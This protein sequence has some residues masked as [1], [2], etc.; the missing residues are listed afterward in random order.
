MRVLH[1]TTEFP[2]VVYG[3]LGT[4]LGGLVLASAASGIEAGVLLIEDHPARTYGTLA[5]DY[6]NSGPPLAD[7]TNLQVPIFRISWGEALMFGLRAVQWWQPDVLHLHVFWLWAV[8]KFLQEHTGIPLVYTVHSLDVAEY[9]FGNGPPQCLT[10]W[11]TQEAVLASANL[12]VAPSESE[13]ELISWYC[14]AVAGRVRV[15]G[16]GIDD[17]PVTPRPQPEPGCAGAVTVLYVGRF[18]DR[19]GIRELLAAIPELLDRAPLARFIL[20]GG[21]RGTTAEQMQSWW[22]PAVLRPTCN[23]LAFT[24]W[25]SPEELREHYRIAD[26]LVVPSWYEPFGMVVLEAMIYGMAIAATRVGGLAEILEHER[27]GLLFQ[28]RDVPALTQSI[29]RLVNDPD[30]RLRLGRAGS[31]EVRRTWLWPSAIIHMHQ[32]YAEA[33]SAS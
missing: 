13:R 23:R 33:V 15:A 11:S 10:Q 21:H 18:V 17:T 30:L 4:A 25:L 24:G 32:I 31:D 7:A 12:I 20:S 9:E 2:P 16:H 22:L 5:A 26:I 1:L 29:L 28:P 3:G 27:T 6:S 19:K 8:A 14:P